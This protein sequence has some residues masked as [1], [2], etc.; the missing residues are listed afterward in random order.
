MTYFH[1]YA[2]TSRNLDRVVQYGLYPLS[3]ALGLI[4]FRNAS[5]DNRLRLA[6][7][8]ARVSSTLGYSALTATFFGLESEMIDANAREAVATE[9]GIDP[10]QV[11]FSD[12]KN[13]DNAIISHAYKDILRLQKYRFGTDMMFMIPT[14]LQ[15]G[16][17]RCGVTW[18]R[19]KSVREDPKEFTASQILLNGHNAWDFGVYAGKAAYWAGETYLMP[20]TGHYEIVKLRENIQST[21]RDIIADDLLAIYQRART[22]KKLPMIE[23][24][25]ALE[26]KA[27]RPLLERMAKEYNKHDGT[28]GVPEIVYLIGTGRINIH[29]RDGVTL[30]SDA[31]AQSFKEIDKVVAVGLKGIRYENMQK[32]A[33]MSDVEK[34]ALRGHKGFVD[35]IADGAF[36][37]A[38]KILGNAR[39]QDKRKPEE[40][41]TPRDP[42]ELTNWNYSINR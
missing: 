12:Y 10:K 6:A 36:N 38:Q 29:A 11:K 26:Y 28:F 4:F 21:G 14:V 9:L 25:S 2:T 32:Y 34:R 3:H 30:S 5:P 15:A 16:A 33:G 1:Y 40:Y 35:K 8:F 37:V 42:G 39:G 17:E 22:D 7:D 20:K 23:N 19:M 27:L 18:P 13:S 24:E 41:I 31:A